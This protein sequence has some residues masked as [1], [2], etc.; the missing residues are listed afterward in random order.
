MTKSGAALAFASQA[1]AQYGEPVGSRPDRVCIRLSQQELARR[2]RCAPSTVSWYLRSLGSAVVTRRGGV[3]FDVEA[4]AGLRDTKRLAPRTA[5][6]ERELLASF[7]RPTGDD[8]QVELL[9]GDPT[10]PR[11]PSLQ[12]LATQLGV[13]R[14]SAHRHISALEAAGR[15]RRD[16]RRLYAVTGPA[17]TKEPLVDIDPSTAPPLGAVTPQ[18]VMELLDKVT[19]LLAMVATMANGLL[20]PAQSAIDGAHDPRICCA[21]TADGAQL[22]AA[23]VAVRTRGFSS[24]EPLTDKTDVEITSNHSASSREDPRPHDEQR[25][26][27]SRIDLPPDWTPDQL[28][29]LLAPLLE[30]CERLGLPGVSDG[31]RVVEAMRP[32]QAGQIAAAARLMAADL[33]AGAPMRSPIAILVAK[34]DNRDPYYFRNPAPQTEPSRPAMVVEDDEQPV[35][36]EAAAAVQELDTEELA[37]LDEVVD[38]HVRRLL[39]ADTSALRSPATL[40]YWR[41]IVWRQLQQPAPEGA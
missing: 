13:N 9:V 23:A 34:A 2:S 41:P 24:K 21:Q 18:Q 38:A 29:E 36:A 28:P 22:R 25:A 8:S 37:R 32:Y 7:A 26:G 35:D 16:G 19:E 11:P 30:A 33:G 14:S 12:D 40:A 20:S 10:N 1:I 5:V 31:Q 6:V 15:F 27:R 4:L 3:V 39:G 17:T